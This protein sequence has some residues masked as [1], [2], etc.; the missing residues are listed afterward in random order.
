MGKDDSL[1]IS[2]LLNNLGKEK[3]KSKKQAIRESFNKIDLGV[4]KVTIEEIIHNT[5][6]AVLV[7]KEILDSIK[8]KLGEN[9]DTL[10]YMLKE[11]P[12][13]LEFA[14]EQFKD[15][16]DVV[17]LAVYENPEAMQFASKRLKQS[18]ELAIFFAKTYRVEALKYVGPWLKNDGELALKLVKE[19][20]FAY[21]YLSE[22]LKNLRL[23]VGKAL[24]TSPSL[25]F[26]LPWKY[27]SDL[28]LANIA[29]ERDFHCYKAVT[30]NIKNNKT[31]AL[32]VIH[33]NYRL[34]PYL[35]KKMREDKDIIN[36]YKNEVKEFENNEEYREAKIDIDAYL[37]ANL[38]NTK[39]LFMK[40]EEEVK[41]FIKRYS[42]DKE[43]EESLL[44]LADE[45]VFSK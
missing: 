40:D 23:L 41:K 20:G 29:S 34:Y 21:Q 26:D 3:I 1:I 25:F 38:F 6:R 39:L 5:G 43:Q 18:K 15:N 17:K 19:N 31:L 24:K 7:D 12:M 10:I 32:K 16:E 37:C 11:N 13:T 8:R 33:Y 2:V 14:S 36:Q 30:P 45:Y 35:S 4:V 27:R 42:L 22:R 28:K 9:L 44:R